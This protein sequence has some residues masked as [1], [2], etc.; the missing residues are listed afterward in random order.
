MRNRILKALS[1]DDF[2]LVAPHLDLV[3]MPN[4]FRVASLVILDYLYFPESGIGAVMSL[5]P[6]GSFEAG[7]FGVEGFVPVY[8]I[9]DNL[10]PYDIEMKVGGAGYRMPIR[11]IAELMLKSASLHGPFVKY[12]HV[13]TNASSVYGSRQRTF[14]S[15]PAP[16]EMDSHVSR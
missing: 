11:M 8:A 14:H 3:P 5:T 10:V 13:F 16:R 4:E 6:N 12:M 2:S 7:M 9:G 1:D 15:R